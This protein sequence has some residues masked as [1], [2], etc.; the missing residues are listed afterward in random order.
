MESNYTKY[1]YA[2]ACKQINLRIKEEKDLSVVNY[3]VHIRR[4]I[5]EDILKYLPEGKD[6]LQEDYLNSNQKNQDASS[7]S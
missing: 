1:S 2:D 6:K 4:K 3:F 7:A 5:I